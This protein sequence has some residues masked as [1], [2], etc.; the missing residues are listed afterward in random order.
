[1]EKAFKTRWWDYHNRK[2]NINGRV[3]LDNL[4]AFGLAGVVLLKYANPFMLSIISKIPTN[5]LKWILI[6]LLLTLL[7]DTIISFVVIGNFK[8]TAN[9]VEKEVAKDST[10]EISNMVKEVTAQKAE[11]IRDNIHEMTDE[12]KENIV[13]R[14]NETKNNAINILKNQVAKSQEKLKS[15]LQYQLMTTKEFTDTVKLRFS[16]TWLNRRF[17]KAFPNLQVKS[18]ILMLNE[19]NEKNE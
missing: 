6:I 16:N 5:I 17:L 14:A 2:F 3:C 19:K 4:A 1:M 13:Q 10:E 11:E 7:V 15:A 18:K 8:K 12:L 9:Q